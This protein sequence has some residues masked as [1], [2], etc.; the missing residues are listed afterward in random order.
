MVDCDDISV[1]E[2]SISYLV[3][4]PLGVVGGLHTNTVHS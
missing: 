1:D 4:T 2:N 3:I